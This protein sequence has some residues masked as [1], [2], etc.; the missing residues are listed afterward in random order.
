[1]ENPDFE[2]RLAREQSNHSLIP[3]TQ[4]RELVDNDEFLPIPGKPSRQN[5]FQQSEQQPI[6][7]RGRASSSV[8][9]NADQF[10]N[11]VQQTRPREDRSDVLSGYQQLNLTQPKESLTIFPPMNK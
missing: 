3:Q 6:M 9:I 11:N 2:S 8:S 4:N 1:M 7:K 5:S 10:L